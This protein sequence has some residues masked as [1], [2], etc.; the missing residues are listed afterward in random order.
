MSQVKQAFSEAGV[1][2]RAIKGFTPRQ[3]Q[4]D[5]ALAVEQVIL[6]KQSLVVEAGTGTGKT[7][8][9]LVPALLSEKKVIVSTGS[10]NLQDQLYH[11]DLPAIK[12][13]LASG[14]STALLKG[15]SN[16]LCIERMQQHCASAP[17]KDEQLLADLVSVQQ[18]EPETQSG[19]LGDLTAIAED[20]LALPYVTST[21]ENCL[22]KD[23]PSFEECYVLK[24]RKKALHADVVVVNH[25]LFFADLALK[26]T[27]FGELVPDVDVVIFD[28]AHQLPDIAADYFGE[29][30]TSRQL[31]ELC[32]DIIKEFRTQLAD[33][34]QLGLAADKLHGTVL[35][36][37]LCFP[38][39]PSRGNWRE[40]L[41]DPMT[42]QT[43]QRLHNDL[44]FLNE[45]IKTNIGRSEVLDHCYDRLTNFQQRLEVLLNLHQP[46]YSLW[47]ETTKRHFSL[48]LTPLTVKEK[49]GDI[50]KQQDKAWVF[51]SA[52]LAVDNGF[53]HYTE[54]MGVEPA[55]ALIL[56]S[57][58]NY[59]QQALLCVPRY[60]PEPNDR[61]MADHIAKLALQVIEANQGRCFFLFTS[62]RML[63]AVTERLN[64]RTMYP[65]LVQGTTSK[66][67][68][69]QQFSQYGN[70][71]LLA[72]G[73]FWE[74]IDVRGNSLTCVVIDKIPFASPDDPMLQARMEDCKREGKDP[75]SH[76]QI[77]QAVITLKQGVGRLIRD[78]K[79]KGALII[80]DN[81]LVTR[82]Y[83]A[84]FVKS[85]PDMHR[86]RDISAVCEFLSTL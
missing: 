24:A 74:G 80:C 57:P 78:E 72:T 2:S 76:I 38:A 14:A 44:D 45:V 36:L 81:R 61:S 1:L 19:D 3:A 56:P 9:Y 21:A 20:S 49:F 66:R 85:L 69:L 64:G 42:Q 25:H 40:K 5:M 71:V 12:K 70:A 82:Q 4:V 18:W 51:T 58:F 31:I 48:K 34:R 65:L 46:G 26:D 7:F 73:S 86:T 23:C 6:S 32:T 17:D 11:R 75:F 47:Y 39:D 63:N 30:L 52:T 15:R 53:A 33:A 35:D 60:L 55:Q 16:Y 84:T 13:V 79:D 67:L 50:L 28:E 27:G 83:G 41:K 62:H 68:L 59:Q 29:S 22:G 43:I 37:R 8:A 77:P 10:K 54:T